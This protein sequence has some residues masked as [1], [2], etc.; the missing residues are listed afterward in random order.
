M[1]KVSIL[2][3]ARKE[4][5]E[6]A[7]GLTVLERTLREVYA[8]ARGDFEVLVGFDGPPFQPL[9]ELAGLKVLQWPRARG[10]KPCLNEMATAA[11]GRYLFKLDAHCAPSE[12]FDIVLQEGMQENWV[13]APRLYVLDPKTW[14]WQD[15]RFYDYFRLPCPL[16]DPKGYR[17]QAG[18]H[19]PARTKERLNIGPLDEN[20][21]LHGSSFFVSRKFF[22]ER[23]GEFDMAHVDQASGEDIEISLKTWLGPW[24]GR[25]M[26]N[27]AVWV[28]HMHKGRGQPRSFRAGQQAIDASYRWTAEYWMENKWLGRMHDLAWLIERFWPV[29]S[30]PEGWREL[31][32]ARREIEA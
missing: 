21:K 1:A 8:Q 5:Q 27:K 14:S 26:V 30:W 32:I 4:V 31:E 20:M 18:G 29:P 6:V 13:V 12:G 2:I 23:L 7:P 17:F 16:T 9:P 19:W 28:A 15:E 3:P 11:T 10:T 22:L 25:V 24:D